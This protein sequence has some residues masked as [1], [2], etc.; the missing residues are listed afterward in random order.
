MQ[1]ILDGTSL[2]LELFNTILHGNFAISLSEEAWNRLNRARRLVE[3]WVRDGEVIYGVT[4]GFGEFANVSIPP[5]QLENL[6]ENLILSH[7]A[8]SGKFLS[9][10]EVRGMMILRINALARGHSGIRRETVEALIAMFNSNVI[11]AVPEEGSVGS[12]GDLVQLSHIALALIG[13]GKCITS[14]GIRPSSEVLLENGITPIRLQAKEGLALI[15]GTQ[16]QCSLGALAINKSLYL[17]KLAD[18]IG[19]M[20]A[21][22]LRSTDRAFDHRIHQLR[23]FTGQATSARRLYELLA[24]SEIRESHRTGDSRVQDAYSIRCM[25]QVHGA[26]HDSIRYAADVFSIELNAVNDNPL[27]F[28]TDGEEVS[29]EFLEGGNFHGQPLAL[30]L[31]FLGIAVAELA[32]ISERRT[33]RLVNGALSNGLPRFLTKNGGIQSG[34]M[35]AQYS[36]ASLVS[37]NKVLAHPA[38]VDSIPTSGN[39]EDH[40]SMGSISALKV[41]T[42]I[43]NLQ[44]VLAIELLCAAQAIDFL[45]PLRTSPLLERLHSTIRSHVPFAETDRILFD[46]IGSIRDLLMAESMTTLAKEIS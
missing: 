43:E 35:I 8:G 27:I 36:A 39:Q 24:G 34:M 28:P 1:A 3:K 46:D 33:E 18:F 13:K 17:A 15:N 37:Q 2:T 44:T 40:N 19:A 9:D 20:T 16:M 21:D 7:S 5:D 23:P 29:G 42:I 30:A 31:D 26:S 10:I 32:N 41:R 38:S 4:T 11:P 6:Q 14:S 22:A 25:P 12:S 45:R